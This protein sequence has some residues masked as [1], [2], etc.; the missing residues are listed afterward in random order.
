MTPSLESAYS[1]ERIYRLTPA[2]N[3]Q[4]DNASLVVQKLLFTMEKDGIDFDRTLSRDW[5]INGYP[6]PGLITYV[7]SIPMSIPPGDGAVSVTSPL[8]FRVDKARNYLVRYEIWGRLED[9][10]GIRPLHGEFLV[11]IK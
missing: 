8:A 2:I 4:K 10:K 11:K 3:H 7:T 9:G 1:K 5:E 6:A